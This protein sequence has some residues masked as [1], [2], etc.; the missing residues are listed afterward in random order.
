[1]ICF[2]FHIKMSYYFLI[3]RSYCKKQKINIIIVEENSIYYLDN[4]DVINEKAENKYRN[5]SGE[6]KKSKKKI[7][8]E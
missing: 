2:F 7:W 6:E 8:N 1:M 4:K 3:E 5:L